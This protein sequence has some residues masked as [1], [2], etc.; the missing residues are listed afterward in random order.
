MIAI[1]EPTPKTASLTSL[2]LNATGMVITVEEN[3]KNKK[4]LQEL[5][6]FS[7]SKVKFVH[8]G[9][10]GGPRAFR[11]MGAVIAIREEDIESIIISGEVC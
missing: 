8:R 4:R 9:R 10:A 11:I 5:G 1:D 6:F 2:A 3:C 7:G